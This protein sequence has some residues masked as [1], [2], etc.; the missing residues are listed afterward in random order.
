MKQIIIRLTKEE[1][2]QLNSIALKLGYMYNGKPSISK[3]L[4]EV[5]K[6]NLKLFSE[7]SLTT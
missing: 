2:Q 7:V 5:A 4:K 1:E 3:I 6:G